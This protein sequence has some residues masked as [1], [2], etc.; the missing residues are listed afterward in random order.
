M[1]GTTRASREGQRWFD[2]AAADL[3]AAEDTAAAGHYHVVCF[4]AQQVAEKALKGFLYSQ[5]E[6]PVIGHAV[7]RLCEA[8]AEYVPEFDA[9]RERIRILDG[10]YI[11]TRYPNGL[12][13]GI[14]AD[15]YNGVAAEQAMELAREALEFCR[16][17]TAGK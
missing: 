3:R 8:C 16:T 6:T 10:Y 17:H 15:V 14:P 11:P 7:H 5:G 1:S 2:Q 13:D 9:L 4:L 12:A